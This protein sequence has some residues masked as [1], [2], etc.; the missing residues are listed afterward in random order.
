MSFT[1]I[2]F[3][4]FAVEVCLSLIEDGNLARVFGILW[5]QSD[6]GTTIG[7]DFPLAMAGKLVNVVRGKGVFCHVVGWY[8]FGRGEAGTAE[9]KQGVWI[10]MIK[11]KNSKITD[12]CLLIQI[13]GLRAFLYRTI[14]F[15]FSPPLPPTIENGRNLEKERKKT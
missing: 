15:R 13:F 1:C 6:D 5:V 3:E 11:P 10:G 8:F 7:G 9:G 14:S 2:D 4:L 12:C